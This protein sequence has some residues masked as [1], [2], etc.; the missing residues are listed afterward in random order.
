MA[1]HCFYLRPG[2]SE[3]PE[4]IAR[5]G[6][7]QDQSRRWNPARIEDV[8]PEL[9]Q[10]FFKSPGRRTRTAGRRCAELLVHGRGQR[11]QRRARQRR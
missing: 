3:T 6:R 4:G 10:Q 11:L 2:Q 7:G 8:A 9:V 1:C 5:L